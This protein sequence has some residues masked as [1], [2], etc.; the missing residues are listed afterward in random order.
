MLFTKR[1]S[2]A[3]PQHCD[4]PQ[5]WSLILSSMQSRRFYGYITR[6]IGG[7][8]HKSVMTWICTLNFGWV[9]FDRKIRK[10]KNVTVLEV[11]LLL[12]T[13]RVSYVSTQYVLDLWHDLTCVPHI[14]KKSVPWRYSLYQPVLTYITNF[15]TTVNRY[16]F[17][18]EWTALHRSVHTCKKHN[19]TT[20]NCHKICLEYTYLVCAII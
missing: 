7:A 8:A 14:S 19:T 16:R 13:L 5:K 1:R 12:E 18:H 20:V 15:L 10:F 6:R 4:F 9:A 11:H 2:C 17:S 3:Q